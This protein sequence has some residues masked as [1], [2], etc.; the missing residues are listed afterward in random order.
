MREMQ[1]DR[2]LALLTAAPAGLSA[3]ELARRLRP[4][5]SQPT[6]WR[7]LDDLR[8]TGRVTVQGRARA[9]RY[10]ASDVTSLDALRS[11]RMHEAAA[12][13]VLRYPGLLH[14]A[15]EHL[16]QLR[17]SNPHGRIYHDQWQEL[18]DGP[19]TRLL[20]VMTEDSERSDTLRKES[21]L[22]VLV[23]TEER[24]RIFDVTR[25]S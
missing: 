16:G 25:R 3:P 5:V 24:R 17:A 18:L 13:Q 22:V 8:R 12:R 15:C 14:R 10:F 19:I 20:R 6:L 1:Q 9:T 21:P 4:R 7:M 2:V 23:P 11:R